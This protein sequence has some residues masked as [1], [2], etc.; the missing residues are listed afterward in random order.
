TPNSPT[1]HV[2]SMDW[3]KRAYEFCQEHDI[4]L[5]SDE[6]YSELYF[7]DAPH[8]ALELGKDNNYDGIIQ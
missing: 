7:E 2:A 6:A 1:G 8:T 5:A 4:I 3:L